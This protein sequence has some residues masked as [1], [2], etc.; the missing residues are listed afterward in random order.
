MNTSNPYDG[1]RVAGTVGVPL[2]G[3]EL[4]I[5]DPETGKAVPEGEIG[6]IEV[7]GPNVFSGYWR[8]PEKPPPNFAPMA[9][10]SPAIS[11]RST[12]AAM[13]RSSA[14][15]AISIITGGFNVY[16]KEIESEIDAMPGVVESRGDRRAPSGFRRGRNRGCRRA[17]THS[18]KRRSLM[19][20]RIALPSYKLPKRLVIR[21][22][23]AAQHHGQGPEEC[24]SRPLPH[25]LQHALATNPSPSRAPSP[26]PNRDKDGRSASKPG[27]VRVSIA[28]CGAARLFVSGRRSGS[29]APVRP[30]TGPSPD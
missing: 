14:A 3:V 19:R 10:S 17:P 6:V 26:T 8:M 16:P 1:D 15:P 13:S 2:A 30:N 9:S 12:T 23:A 24:A 11:A 21:G 18:T 25:A 27:L 5:A 7:R 22:R 28:A 20:S 4:R 29:A